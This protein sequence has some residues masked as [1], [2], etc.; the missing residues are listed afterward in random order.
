MSSRQLRFDGFEAEA[1]AEVGMAQAWEADRVQMWKILAAEYLFS[2]SS[3][4]EFT[5]DDMVAEIGLPDEGVNRNNVV[6]A[7]FSAH[8]KAGDIV[9]ANRLG[10]SKRVVRH[11]NLQRVWRV[12]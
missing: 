2:L 6:G 1:R 8:A 3:G 11:G 5:A 4:T 10:R 7:W 12:A 9:F